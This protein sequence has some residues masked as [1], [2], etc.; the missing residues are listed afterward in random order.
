MSFKCLLKFRLD[1]ICVV[2]TMMFLPN[3]ILANETITNAKKLN[4]TA[5]PASGAYLAQLVIGLII[6]LFCI[7]VLAWLAKRFNQFKSSSTG[8]LQIL[9]GVSM[10]ARERVVLVQVGSSQLLLGVSPGGINTLHVLTQDIANSDTS[11]D[12]NVSPQP[13][14]ETFSEKLSSILSRDKQ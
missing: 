11:T 8:V 12:T 9:G 7:I 6:V 1:I 14:Q 4:V 5:D 3:S 13:S 2:M 10:G